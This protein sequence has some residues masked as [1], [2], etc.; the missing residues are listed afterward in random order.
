MERHGNLFDRI[1]HPDNLYAAYRAAAKG[2]RWQKAVKRFEEDVPGNLLAL[3]KALCTG[4]YRTAKYK[5]RRI[6]EPK[7]RI[8]YILPF[9]PD[10]IVQHAVVRVLEPIWDPLF[11]TDS[12]ASR[13]GKGMHRGSAKAMRFIRNYDYV[14][15][16]DISKFYPSIDQAVLMGIIKR[17]IKCPPTLSLLEEIVYSYPGGK[18]TPIGNYTSQWFGNLYLN[19]LDMAVKH[20]LKCRAYV[21]YC[22]D[23][24]IFSNDK[25]CLHQIKAWIERF[26]LGTLRLRFSHW[27][28]APLTTG[29]DFLGYRHWRHK[30]LARKATV[31]RVKC[32]LKRLAVRLAQGDYDVQKARSSLASTEGWL[33]WCNSYNLRKALNLSELKAQV[34]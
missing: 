11:I 29:L 6:H 28:V 24:V 21:R 30:I 4:Q 1:T 34:G 27:A 23:F 5:T 14:L 7:K 16:A 19:E 9:Y 15:K 3:Q 31:K 17:K 26:L 25:K 2:K 8:I 20:D 32:R 12:Y 33:L 10:R 13:K 18:N 22:D